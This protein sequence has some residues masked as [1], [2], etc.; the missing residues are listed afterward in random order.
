MASSTSAPPGVSAR[1][2]A[3]GGQLSTPDGATTT[4]PASRSTPTTQS[5]NASVS[6]RNEQAKSSAST[7]TLSRAGKGKGSASSSR[8]QQPQSISSS[9]RRG[10]SGNGNEQNNHVISSLEGVLSPSQ[11]ALDAAAKAAAMAQATQEEEETICLICADTATFW[12]VGVCNHRTCHTCSIRLRALYK[13]KECT[14]CKTE[15]DRVVFTSS[16]DR[17]YLDFPD[18]VVPFSDAKVS[19][20]Q[21]CLACARSAADKARPTSHRQL[22]ISFETR[23]QMDDSLALLRF[24]CPISTCD[25]ICLGWGDLK[26]HVRSSH[27]SNLC[28]LCCSNKKIFAHEHSTFANRELNQHIH[29]DHNSCDF[30]RRAF[31][32]ADQLYAHCRDAHEE[33]FICVRQGIRHQYHLNY[34]QLEAHYK[35]AHYLCLHPTCLEKKFIVFETELDLQ[36]HAVQE[37]GAALAGDQRSRR[38]A[39]RIETNFT[40]EAADAGP[41][42]SGR[43]GRGDTRGGRRGGRGGGSGGDGGRRADAAPAAAAF[44]STTDAPNRSRVIPGLGPAASLTNGSTSRANRF[45][46]ALT[47]DSNPASAPSSGRATPDPTTV[48]RH[49]QVMRLVADAVAGSEAKVTSFKL[50]IRAFRA[51]EVSA[52]DLVDQLWN[53]FD[54]DADKAEPIVKGVAGLMEDADKKAA[55]HAAWRDRRIEQNQFPSLT[56]L[57]PTLHGVP[58]TTNNSSPR[59]LNSRSTRNQRDP[60]IWARVEQAANRPG[61]IVS[62]NPFPALSSARNV[63]PGMAPR[64]PARGLGHHTP[65]SASA[66]GSGAGSSTSTPPATRYPSPSPTLGAMPPLRSSAHPPSSMPVTR[67]APPPSIARSTEFPSLPVSTTEIDRRARMRAAM[68]KPSQTILDGSP[69]N[70]RSASPWGP[71]NSK[72]EQEVE[73]ETN[74]G[75]TPGVDKKKKKKTK[76][77]LMSRG[78]HHA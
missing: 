16:P 56:A 71:S 77:L 43:G 21:T 44:V 49:A 1:R 10:Q 45:G 31:Y 74:E 67:Q 39:R 19:R 63:V 24:N 70:E 9:S 27:Q 7:N 68:G 26:R 15:C 5:S 52:D 42:M 61:A 69:S 36:A 50:A 51:N 25:S 20:A 59:A 29:N 3:F 58:T 55:L 78:M 57:A 8:S 46:A 17:P 34:S 76:V 22:G 53:V 48:E 11:A 33:C 23:E 13:K 4:V 41:P 18:S 47:S 64:Q 62:A 2:A 66:S 40:Y 72:D 60:N 32:D 6:T 12:A 30:C 38:D 14:L 65:W 75:V 37:H 28:D 35:A 73:V 54:Q